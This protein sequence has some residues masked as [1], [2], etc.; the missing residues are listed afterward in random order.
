MDLNSISSIVALVAAL[1]VAS[2]RLVEII[3]GIIPFLNKENPDPNAEGYRQA[4]LHVLAVVAGIVTAWLA[5]STAAIKSVLPDTPLAW[6]GV[7][8]LASGGS[9]FWNSIQGYVN[10]AK[11]VKT[12]EAANKNL[13]AQAKKATLAAP[14]A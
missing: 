11:D 5:S 7:G 12:A 13:D 14:S 2:E 3:K 8:L 9:G 10:K 1:S 4:L 6:I